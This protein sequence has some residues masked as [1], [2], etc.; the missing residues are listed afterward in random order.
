MQLIRPPLGGNP[1]TEV[2][3]NG[4]D[5]FMEG[6]FLRNTKDHPQHNTLRS[7]VEAV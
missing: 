3:E 7:E 5:Q 4:D 6:E 1:V 2:S